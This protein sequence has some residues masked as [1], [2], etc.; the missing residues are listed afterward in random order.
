MSSHNGATR[1]GSRATGS[2]SLRTAVGMQPARAEVVAAVTSSDD[3]PAPIG[4]SGGSLASRSGLL[5]RKRNTLPTRREGEKRA[6]C[7]KGS[8]RAPGPALDDPHYADTLANGESAG[9]LAGQLST[10]GRKGL[11]T[12][13]PRGI[14]TPDLPIT[15]TPQAGNHAQGWQG[16]AAQKG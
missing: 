10:E 3:V 12:W 8:C 6:A 13:S 9:S 1:R 5:A 15:R 16:S 14:R 4:R 11:L 2:M 7:Q